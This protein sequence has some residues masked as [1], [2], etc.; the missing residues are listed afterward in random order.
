MKVD[1]DMKNVDVSELVEPDAWD[2]ALEAHASNVAKETDGP[3]EGS[4]QERDGD[5][6]ERTVS[7]DGEDHR[8]HVHHV[9][10]DRPAD[11]VGTLEQL[12]CEVCGA[13]VS[14]LR[15][16]RCWG[17]YQKW[18]ES[19]SVGVGARCVVCGDRR[20]ENL[21]RVELFGRW[22]PMCHICAT[23]T[24]RLSPMPRSVEGIRQRLERDRRYGDRREDSSDD[25]LLRK[26]RRVG[27]RRV[28]P[29]SDEDVV[30][31]EDLIIEIEPETDRGN[32]QVTS[33][34]DRLDE[35]ELA[36][37][38]YG[39]EADDLDDADE[40]NEPEILEASFLDQRPSI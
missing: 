4:G 1:V 39:I 3:L 21:Q 12:Q 36:Y 25:R 23:R 20:R 5:E 6:Q 28:L 34:F 10:A 40:D 17:C 2:E 35:E 16:G 11:A 22:F 7:I 15:R 19:Q 24:M 32:V 9:H 26:E 33:L 38:D 30:E 13:R 29:I 18:Q 14:T 31:I 8:E 27:E 37:G